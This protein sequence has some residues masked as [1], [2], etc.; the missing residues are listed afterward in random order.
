MDYGIKGRVAMAACNIL[1][2]SPRELLSQAIVGVVRSFPENHR[3]VFVQVHYGGRPVE[4]AA[5][6]L[7][8]SVSEAR[9]ILEQCERKLVKNLRQ[10]RG[11]TDCSHPHLRLLAL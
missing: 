1:V 8:I 11:T 6:S 5:R 2:E 3:R 9:Q 7:G 4:E 10:F